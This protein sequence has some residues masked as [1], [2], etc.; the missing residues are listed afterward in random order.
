M[1]KQKRKMA[2]EKWSNSVLY[3]FEHKNLTVTVFFIFFKMNLPVKLENV[4]KKCEGFFFVYGWGCEN[5]FDKKFF[6]PAIWLKR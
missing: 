6:I 5:C 1:G 4:W 2:Y 3:F